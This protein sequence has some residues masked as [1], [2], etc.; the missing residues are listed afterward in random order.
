MSDPLIHDAIKS[1]IDAD[2]TGSNADAPR[3]VLE[4]IAPLEG[5]LGVEK[6]DGRDKDL[7]AFIKTEIDA[8]SNAEM[9]YELRMIE[10]R[11]SPPKL[12]QR[13]LDLVYGYLKAKAAASQ[14]KKHAESFLDE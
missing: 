14:Y 12:G 6:P 1:H 4:D 7:M 3:P 11:L 13:R 10:R 2:F 8:P 5:F 9:L